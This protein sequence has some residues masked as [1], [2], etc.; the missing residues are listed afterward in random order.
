MNDHNNNTQE[1]KDEK[2][3]PVQKNDVRKNGDNPNQ[4]HSK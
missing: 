3:H 4:S 2:K 1:Q